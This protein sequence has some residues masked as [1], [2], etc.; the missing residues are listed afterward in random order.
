M[1]NFYYEAHFSDQLADQFT[2]IRL[3][4]LELL[5]LG[6]SNHNIALECHTK[7]K[8]IEHH[9]T[10]MAHVYQIKT[11]IHNPRTRILAHLYFN[12]LMTLRSPADPLDISLYTPKILDVMK[13]LLIGLSLKA[14]AAILNLSVKA[15]EQRIGQLYD[16]FNVDTDNTLHENCRVVLWA[17]ILLRTE[18]DKKQLK[19]LY[20]ETSVE[21]IPRVLA[22]PE[23]FLLRLRGFNGQIG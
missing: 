15:V 1:S 13:L 7:I 3:T 12:D 22:N 6:Y 8:T 20:E 10:S 19:K 23:L 9:L 2:T 5:A 16:S 18:T 21:K 4:V 11:D 17:A 14:T